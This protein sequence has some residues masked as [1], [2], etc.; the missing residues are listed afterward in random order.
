[1]RHQV[2]GRRLSRDTNARKA[3]L[4]NLASSLIMKGKVTTTLAKAKFVGPFVEKLV[5]KIKKNKLHKRRAIATL[6][7]KKAFTK[8]VQEITPSLIDRAG[9]YTRI[10]RLGFRRGDAA[11][12]ARIEFVNWNK[13]K[14][15]NQTASFKKKKRKNMKNLK[16]NAKK[17]EEKQR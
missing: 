8:L 2:F 10:V 12:V 11:E 4:A 16:T 9:G 7:T 17:Q 14:T 13:L 6:L 1:M 5:T 15:N 3:L